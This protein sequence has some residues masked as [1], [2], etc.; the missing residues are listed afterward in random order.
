MTPERWQQVA[1]LYEEVLARPPEERAEYLARQSGDDLDLRTQ[2]GSLLAHADR[3]VLVDQSVWEAADGLIDV[4]LQPA[5]PEGY[6]I[7]PY[8]VGRLLGIGGMGHVYRARDTKLQR[9]VALKILPDA[10]VQDPDRVARFTRE[11]RVLASLNHTNIGTIYGFENSDHIHALVLELVDAPTLEDRI[12]R[13]ALPFDE[14][15]AIARQIVD[16][17]EATHAVGIVHRD[18]KPANIK[19]REDVVV[20]VLDFGLAKLQPSYQP[21]DGEPESS[22]RLP[23]APSLSPTSE[24]RPEITTAGGIV[25]TAAYMSPEQAR[26]TACD[27]RSDI[28][29]FGCVLYEMLAGKRAFAGRDVAD[30]I[31]SIIEREPDWDAIHHVPAPLQR[32][33]TRCLQKDRKRR[34]ADIADARFDFDD[35]HAP[36]REEEHS[37]L[38]Q[39]ATRKGRVAWALSGAGVAAVLTVSL[40]V[41]F[42]PAAEAPE[43]RLEITTPA[44]DDPLSLAV[45]PDGR[46][47]VFVAAGE[48]DASAQL[49]LRPLAANTA[50]PL[51]NTT[52]ETFPFWSSDSKSVAFFA[53]RK[54]KRLDLATGVVRDLADAGGG[55]GGSCAQANWTTCRI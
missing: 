13:G 14:A 17:L 4:D 15:I 53:F 55:G 8:R 11:A 31:A 12:A 20:K 9:D 42:R 52:G 35:A 41:W 39:H 54:L 51:P 22:E 44:T 29:A 32:L 3:P 38:S 48:R 33:L 19:V 43:T 40:M 7:G 45:S 25:G 28:W 10:F 26:G 36:P 16:A 47:V 37:R 5:L 6:E 23:S 18:L 30:T 46:K 24:S 27:K 34:L 49:W 1:G 21:A 2:V 50:M